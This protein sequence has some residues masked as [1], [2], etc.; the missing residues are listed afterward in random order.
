MA[1]VCILI[2]FGKI[3]GQFSMFVIAIQLV[4][5]PRYTA[6]WLSVLINNGIIVYTLSPANS[7]NT[8]KHSMALIMTCYVSPI[9]CLSQESGRYQ[10]MP[11]WLTRIPYTL[12]YKAIGLI[13]PLALRL[14]YGQAHNNTTACLM[15]TFCPLEQVEACIV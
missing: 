3:W 6:C 10:D 13:E 11:A 4:T 7:E 14:H 8:S 12:M 9:E 1:A 15:Y 2:R 5:G